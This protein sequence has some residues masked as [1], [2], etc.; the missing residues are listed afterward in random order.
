MFFNC[1]S[2]EKPD[3]FVNCSNFEQSLPKMMTSEKS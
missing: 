3:H 2:G 1:L